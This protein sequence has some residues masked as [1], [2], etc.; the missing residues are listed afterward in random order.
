MKFLSSSLNHCPFKDLDAILEKKSPDAPAS[1]SKG[2]LSIDCFETEGLKSDRVIFEEAMQDVIPLA[3]RGEVVR[4]PANTLIPV[5]EANSSDEN[6]IVDNL[7]EL[8]SSGKGF[9]VAHTPEYVEGSSLNRHAG[10]AKRLHRGDFSIQAHIDL[11][12]LTVIQAREALNSFMM[13][14]IAAGKRAVLVIHGR[15]RSS[16]VKPILKGKVIEWLSESPLKKWVIAFTS[17]RLCDGGAGATYVMLRQ[18]P[19]TKKV[20]KGSGA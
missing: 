6:T 20:K 7:K 15:G 12:G 13:D 19:A 10:I 8:V 2:S 11:H 18:R 3:K 17:A 14:S 5:S 4:I 1:D 9:V 16:P